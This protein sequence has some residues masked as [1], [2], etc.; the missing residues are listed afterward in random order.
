MYNQTSLITQEIA[1][2]KKRRRRKKIIKRI[3]LAVI[4]ITIGIAVSSKFV[5]AAKT[6]ARNQVQAQM[7]KYQQIKVIVKKGDTIWS[8]Q[9]NLTPNGNIESLICLAEKYAGHS[10]GNVQP[11]ETVV[12]FK[13]R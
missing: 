10:L 12:L 3:I 4:V 9:N 5:K 1:E 8:L 2:M 6:V 13:D 7:S 11:G